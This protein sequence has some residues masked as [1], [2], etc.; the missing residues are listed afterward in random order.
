MK[1][2]S[3]RSELRHHRATIHGRILKRTRYDIFIGTTRSFLTNWSGWA[4]EGGVEMIKNHKQRN[5][6][7]NTLLRLPRDTVKL[8]ISVQHTQFYSSHTPPPYPSLTRELRLSCD[9]NY[10]ERVH[11]SK[12]N[13]GWCVK[14]SRDNFAA[15]RDRGQEATRPGGKSKERRDVRAS[16][17]SE[18]ESNWLNWVE[19][20][21]KL[22]V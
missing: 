1:N 14:F 4:V 3:C 11:G 2:C 17:A 21:T 10:I 22:N 16:C 19:G 13:L 18:R 15:K 7:K 9:Q 8:E 12:K 20:Q 6:D 5:K